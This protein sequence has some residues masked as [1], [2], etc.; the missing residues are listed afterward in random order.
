MYK[1]IFFDVS[2]VIL[3]PQ[4]ISS[5]LKRNSSLAVGIENII[6][7]LSKKYR[8]I[9]VSNFSG[10]TLQHYLKE[11]DIKKYFDHVISSH[12]KASDMKDIMTTYGIDPH[13]CIMITDTCN[14]IRAAQAIKIDTIAVTWG[15]TN[16]SSLQTCNPT[17][18]IDNPTEITKIIKKHQ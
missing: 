3:M 10:T 12:D 9:V 16:H 15:Y 14:D 1:I 6:K 18:I 2:G 4:T 5:V 17:Y 7:E 13:E 11:W 8:I